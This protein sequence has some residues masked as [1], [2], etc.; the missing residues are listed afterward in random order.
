M[1]ENT[2]QKFLVA[3]VQMEPVWMDRQA[4]TEKI[5]D[6]IRELGKQG[7]RLIVFPETIIPGT[8]HWTWFDP[9]NSELF[10]DLI[11]NAVEVPGPTLQVIAQACRDAR[12][13]VI[14]GIHERA[15]KALY[16][17]LVHINESG[18]LVNNHRKLMGTH[19]EKVL[20][21]AG[22]A[23]GLRTVQTPLGKVGG[24]ICAEHNM[25]LPRHT[26]AQESEEIH[27]ALFISGAARRGAQFNDWVET[28]CRSYALANQTYVICAQSV[29]SEAEI[30]KFDLLGPGGGSSIIAPDG[31]YLA[32]PLLG[33]EG[34]VV[35]EIDRRQGMRFYSLFDTV[36]YHGR[37]DIFDLQ[38]SRSRYSAPSGGP[39]QIPI[40]LL[41]LP[42]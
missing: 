2:L 13:N 9:A 31:S 12:A 25:S 36:G 40:P 26:L 42:A 35:A 18:E 3:A 37:P 34:D 41:E 1:S 16:N 29:A 11:S 7:V 5:C 27:A 32:E 24:L 17:S 14:L 22:D 15:G 30:S 19:A 10:L 20:W 8:P 4:T 21:A 6:K 38:V 28:W 39:G 33:R 23:T